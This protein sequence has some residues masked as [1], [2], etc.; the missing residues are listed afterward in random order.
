[1]TPEQ[2]RFLGALCLFGVVAI[3]GY[4][5]YSFLNVP[6]S[7][8]D[9]YEFPGSVV[10]HSDASAPGGTATFT[11]KDRPYSGDTYV[12]LLAQDM[13][14]IAKH[15][16]ES[17]NQSGELQFTF[18]ADGPDE[19]GN[20][21]QLLAFDISYSM[22]DLRQVNWANIHAMSL[23]N[24]ATIID[25]TPEGKK[26]LEEYCEDDGDISNIFCASA[27]QRFPPD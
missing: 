10:R 12:T 1:M 17:R 27:K 22:D 2:R 25:I 11:L 15:A 9:I 5:A 24:L 14:K 8:S 23:L 4:C 20:P 18:M 7:S 26:V 16:V 13:Y 6:G 3:V 21:T 19:H